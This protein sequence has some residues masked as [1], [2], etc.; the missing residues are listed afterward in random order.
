M[1]L[2]SNYINF[3]DL[4]RMSYCYVFVFRDP[5]NRMNSKKCIHNVQTYMSICIKLYFFTYNVPSTNIWTSTF[6]LKYFR[7]SGTFKRFCSVKGIPNF[8]LHNINIVPIQYRQ[9]EITLILTKSR[10]TNNSFRVQTLLYLKFF[11]L[12]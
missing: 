11:F 3:G 9:N 10:S 4:I 6:R 2:S 1:H 8:F 7:R 12:F 5:C